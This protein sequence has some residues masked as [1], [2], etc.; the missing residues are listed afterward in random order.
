M[1]ESTSGLVERQIN[2]IAQAL[3]LL[4]QLA[5]E[6]LGQVMDDGTT[7]WSDDVVMDLAEAFGIGDEIDGSIADIFIARALTPLPSPTEET[8]SW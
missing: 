2:A 5:G 1:S 7:L 8:G 3:R 6:G 4:D